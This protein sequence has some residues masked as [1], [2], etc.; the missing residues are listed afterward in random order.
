MKNSTHLGVLHWMFLILFTLKV[1]QWDTPI[2]D[3]SWWWV[4]AP[5]WGLALLMFLGGFF[6]SVAKGD[7]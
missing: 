4:T 3:L 6:G 1:G 5:V 2:A 7:G